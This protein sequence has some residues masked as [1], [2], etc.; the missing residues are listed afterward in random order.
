MFIQ[1]TSK[2]GKLSS[3][4][5]ATSSNVWNFSETMKWEKHN[6]MQHDDFELDGEGEEGERAPF[7]IPIAERVKSKMELYGLT[8]PK[9]T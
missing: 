9:S 6:K 7:Q 1:D 5:G 2:L 3:Q 4:A 8:V